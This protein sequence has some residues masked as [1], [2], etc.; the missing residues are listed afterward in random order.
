MIYRVVSRAI[1]LSAA[2]ALTLPSTVWAEGGDA[3][4]PASPP[5]AEA[6]T[7]AYGEATTCMALY[8][9]LGSQYDRETEEAEAFRTL[10]VA[11]S[12][13][14]EANY[15]SE[16]LQNGERDVPTETE[17]LADEF[18]AMNEEQ[19]NAEIERHIDNC[20]GLE[21]AGRVLK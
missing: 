20:Q 10:I 16:F 21:D 19:F 17:R 2:L 15:P 8:I 14:T 1:A 7:I 18:N 5:P 3:P 6:T 13:F 12:D 4:S 9:I 11:W